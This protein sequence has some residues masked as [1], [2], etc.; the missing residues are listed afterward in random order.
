MR[1][2]LTILALSLLSL[3]VLAQDIPS[4]RFGTWGVDLSSMDKSVKPGDNFFDYV[5]GAWLKTAQIPPDRSQTGSFQDLQIL[6]ERRMQAIM[7]DLEKKPA[8]ALAP[9]EKKLRDLYDAF[10][11]TKAIEAN[12]LKPAQKDLDYFAGLKSLDDV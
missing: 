12:G 7:D 2:M 1:P 9:E 6:S 4:P 8:A 11:D 10:E 3:P 5:N